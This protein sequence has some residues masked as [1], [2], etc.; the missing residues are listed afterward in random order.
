MTMLHQVSSTED[1]ERICGSGNV[2]PGQA[3]WI[4][5]G[6]A[7]D[8]VVIAS[9][10]HPR[11]QSYALFGRSVVRAQK[12]GTY[13]VRQEAMLEVTGGQGFLAS[14]NAHVTAIRTP[15]EA[16]ER[17]RVVA[18]GS[19]VDVSEF[20]H[21]ET[22]DLPDTP[23]NASSRL[24][25]QGSAQ[26]IVRGR[27]RADV[28]DQA[29]AEG[30]DDARIDVRSAMGGTNTATVVVHDRATCVVHGFAGDR[31]RVTADGEAQVVIEGQGTSMIE[32]RGNAKVIVKSGVASVRLTE[33]AHADV[34][35]HCRVQARGRA[36]VVARR[37]AQV[38][39]SDAA[40]IDVPGAWWDVD[41][42][43]LRSAGASAPVTGPAR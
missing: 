35:A 4:D 6:T 25:L 9:A 21:V 27:A 24:V 14:G 32:A 2:Q 34:G 36:R 1:L 26:G 15:G 13:I 33:D 20:A 29:R 18:Q 28:G 16:R 39:L 11:P 30:F 10:R 7:D 19:H 31:I 12:G 42:R 3:V 40:M 43:D 17:A 5:G 23:A 22:A 8:P 37:G 41:V 38:E